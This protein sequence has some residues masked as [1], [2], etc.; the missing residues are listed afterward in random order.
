M[1]FF[2][3]KYE[4]GYVNV[5]PFTTYESASGEEIKAGE[6]LV[7]SA[8]KL[9]K[10]GATTAPKYIS[11]TN[12]DKNATNRVINVNIINKEQVWRAACT[13]DPSA[14]KPGDKITLSA[15][16]LGVTNTTTNGVATVEKVDEADKTVLVRFA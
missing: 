8:G 6:A 9:T 16:A 4:G 7:L 12:L 13:A 15:D 14:L 2:L 11:M 10:C 3:A 1:A 5:G